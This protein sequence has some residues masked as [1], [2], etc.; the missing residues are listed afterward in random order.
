MGPPVL[1]DQMQLDEPMREQLNQGMSL[2]LLERLGMNDT[3]EPL[4]LQRLDMN[5]MLGMNQLGTIPLDLRA[6]N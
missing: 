2:P 5:E 1:W 3:H 6:K 4:L